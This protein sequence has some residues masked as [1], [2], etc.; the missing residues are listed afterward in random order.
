ML[1]ATGAREGPPARIPPTGLGGCSAP[2]VTTASQV[3]HS[4]RPLTQG[5][6]VGP[7]SFPCTVPVT[8]SESIAELCKA[9]LRAYLP[10]TPLLHPSQRALSSPDQASDPFIH[11][12]SFLDSRS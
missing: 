4:S 5:V 3:H 2:E 9:E 6:G 12:S 11:R 1:L 10:R 8:L 7:E